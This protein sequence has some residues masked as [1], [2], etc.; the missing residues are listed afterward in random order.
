ME[1]LQRALNVWWQFCGTKHSDDRLCLGEPLATMWEH[2]LASG[3]S[4]IFV[5]HYPERFAFT[6]IL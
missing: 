2:T 1:Y 6:A 3:S 4:F 5:R